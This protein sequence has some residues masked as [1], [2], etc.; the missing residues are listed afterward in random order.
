[1]F[2]LIAG[3]YLVFYDHRLPFSIGDKNVDIELFPLYEHT[4]LI[5]AFDLG[6]GVYKRL[7]VTPLFLVRFPVIE[8]RRKKPGMQIDLVALAA[9]HRKDVERFQIRSNVLLV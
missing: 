1:M 2:G 8:Q 6:D 4:V 3:P 9:K 7:K 5:E